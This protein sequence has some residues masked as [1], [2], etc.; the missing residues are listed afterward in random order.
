MA[1]GLSQEELAALAGLSRRGISDLERATRRTPYK[2]TVR[3]LAEAL[4]L[5]VRARAEFQAAARRAV[6][7]NAHLAPG[8][9]RAPSATVVPLPLTSFVGREREVPAIRHALLS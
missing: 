2:E 8:S 7:T 3:R 9:D 1:A 5:D 4:H 6:R